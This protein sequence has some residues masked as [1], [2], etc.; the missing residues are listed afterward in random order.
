V[1]QIEKALPLL[2]DGSPAALS[3][4]LRGFLLEAVPP[5]LYE[6]SPGWGRQAP[7]PKG[8]Q[9]KGKGLKRHP[10]IKKE[11]RNHGTWRKIKVQTV[12]LR[13]SLIVDL[14]DIQKHDGG[15]TTFTVFLS[16][17]AR[18]QLVQEKWEWGVRLYSGS[19]QAR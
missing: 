13:D 6:A 7:A 9:W 12:N 3:A 16:F 18:V 14:R 4:A 19:A 1:G 2:Q 15:R 17:D 8:L 11:N 5:T 10:A